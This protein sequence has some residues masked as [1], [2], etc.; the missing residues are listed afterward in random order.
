MEYGHSY[1]H[2]PGNSGHVQS[3]GLAVIIVSPLHNLSL[4]QPD[5]VGCQ[6]DALNIAKDG[7]WN[8]YVKPLRSI[9]GVSLGEI[10]SEP[11]SD[12]SAWC[13]REC[14]SS[15]LSHGAGARF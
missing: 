13:A 9:N 12:R 6:V 11:I 1:S 5:H 14:M 10:E 2:N 8:Q 7:V 4:A 3:L 15:E